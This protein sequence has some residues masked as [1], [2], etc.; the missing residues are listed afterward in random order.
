MQIAHDQRRAEGNLFFLVQ[1]F[2]QT[3]HPSHQ[4]RPRVRHGHAAALH[5]VGQARARHFHGKLGNHP[6]IKID[7][8]GKKGPFRRCIHGIELGRHVHSRHQTLIFTVIV[9]PVS[10]HGM[11]APLHNQR[12]QRPLEAAPPAVASVAADQRQPLNG[13]RIVPRSVHAPQQPLPQRGV[14]LR[15]PAFFIFLHTALNPIRG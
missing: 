1:Q 15:N 14:Y 6:L 9:I 8:Q 5:A 13:S 4:I 7:A 2:H 3:Q 12:G 11:L 10:K